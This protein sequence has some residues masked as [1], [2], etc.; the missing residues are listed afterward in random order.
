MA[1]ETKSGS[2]EDPASAARRV[3]APVTRAEARARLR[4]AIGT[5]G[6]DLSAAAARAVADI[7]LGLANRG[8]QL[9]FL[10]D[11]VDFVDDV[12][13]VTEELIQHLV[14][15][16]AIDDVNIPLIFVGTP[17]EPGGGET[18]P[19][20][21]DPR[22]ASAKQILEARKTILEATAEL[23]KKGFQAMAQS[24]RAQIAAM[25]RPKP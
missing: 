23:R 25:R 4:G 2:P 3:H 18:V 5:T 12:V 17:A 13:D 1:D 14:V 6:P 15:I 8:A 11:V 9:G 24:L 7:R 16:T 22:G 19:G 10:D 21:E 20:A